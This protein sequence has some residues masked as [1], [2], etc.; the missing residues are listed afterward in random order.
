MAGPEGEVAAAA[1]DAAIC[2][3][4]SATWVGMT[5]FRIDG[6]VR[7]AARRPRRKRARA[8]A[9]NAIETP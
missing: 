4:G 9:K 7:A 3:S 2:G 6:I 8:A 5:T 1:A